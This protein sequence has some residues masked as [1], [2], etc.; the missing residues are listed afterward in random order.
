MNRNKDAVDVFDKWADL[1]QSKYMNVDRYSS[2]IDLFINETRKIGTR[3][4]DIACGPGNIARYLLGKFPDMNL[5]GIDLAPSMIKLARVNNPNANFQVMD[6]RN[7]QEL[8]QNFDGIIAA[9]VLPY[10]DKSEVISL[11]ANIS[12]L[13]TSNGILYLSTIEGRPE[14][15]GL[16]KGSTG[17]EVYQHYYE[18]SFLINLLENSGL[19]LIDQ[20]RSIKGEKTDASDN[21][22]V[23]I[24]KRS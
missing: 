18:G 22:L 1:Y 20:Q 2:S 23:I 14:D 7:I 17:D 21:E 16:R 4:L 3:V 19:C 15:S 11:V 5:L 13:L 12:Q 8:E 6:S 9:F 24:A 10:L